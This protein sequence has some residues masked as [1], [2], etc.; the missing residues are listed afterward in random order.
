MASKLVI[1]VSPSYILLGEN[2][3]EIKVLAQ[4]TTDTWLY[5]LFSQ[6]KSRAEYSVLRHAIIRARR[7]DFEKQKTSCGK[8]QAH[9]KKWSVY[10]FSALHHSFHFSFSMFK[11]QDRPVVA[12]QK[13][14]FFFPL[15]NKLELCSSQLT[16]STFSYS[17]HGKGVHYRWSKF[18]LVLGHRIACRVG[19]HDILF[20][21]IFQI[22]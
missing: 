1:D 22:Y 21:T 3:A 13:M 16:L 15:I 8:S 19:H 12:K 17:E 6:K 10:W 9:Q 2:N 18:D 5:V 14:A 4:A 11:K 7:F 20:A